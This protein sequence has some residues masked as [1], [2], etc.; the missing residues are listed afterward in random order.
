MKFSH[1]V[2]LILALTFSTLRG[3]EFTVTNDLDFTI[4]VVDYSGLV[5]LYVPP[6]TRIVHITGDMRY[7]RMTVSYSDGV[8]DSFIQLNFNNT[9]TPHTAWVDQPY[10]Q[11]NG[12]GFYIGENTFYGALPR[13]TLVEFSYIPS[14]SSSTSIWELPS[15]LVDATIV[16][17]GLGEVGLPDWALSNPAMACF[18]FGFATGAGVIFVRAGLRWFKR[19]DGSQ[20]EV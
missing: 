17:P 20:G 16:V 18:F 9:G 1:L 3:V 8:D 5:D 7:V 2:F 12:R 4:R 14:P 6:K 13:A 15:G 10:S 11:L 19:A